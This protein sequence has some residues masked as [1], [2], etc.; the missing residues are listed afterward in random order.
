VSKYDA[1]WNSLSPQT[2]EYL[3]KQPIW[4]DRDLYKALAIG[5]VV[6]FVIG[7]IVG[8]EA[9]WRPIIQTFRPLIG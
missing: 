5:A 8:F 9:A 1:W 2:Q 7:F 6:G 4:H 3:K